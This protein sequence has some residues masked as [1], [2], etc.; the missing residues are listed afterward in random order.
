LADAA[1]Q[2]N[3]STNKQ[4]NKSN[5][6]YETIIQTIYNQVSLSGEQEAGACVIFSPLGVSGLVVRRRQYVGRLWQ[7]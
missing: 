4:I 6:G 1:K 5:S 2:I 7:F 3:N